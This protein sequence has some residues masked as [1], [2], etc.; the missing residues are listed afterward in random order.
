MESVQN[1]QSRVEAIN[2]SL[3]PE[4]IL[5]DFNQSLN[6][7][8]LDNAENRKMFSVFEV[9]QLRQLKPDTGFRYL[10][11]DFIGQIA[12]SDVMKNRL[13]LLELVI[14][15]LSDSQSYDEARPKRLMKAGSPQA[16]LRRTA[17][18][19]YKGLIIP[20]QN[21]QMGKFK[22]VE[23]PIGTDSSLRRPSVD[24]ALENIGPVWRWDGNFRFDNQ[25]FSS[26]NER[27]VSQLVRSSERY[28][29]FER[30]ELFREEYDLI[31]LLNQRLGEPPY[32][33]R[34]MKELRHTQYSEFLPKPYKHESIRSSVEAGHNLTLAVEDLWRKAGIIN[35]DLK[36]SSIRERSN[37]DLVIVDWGVN[38]QLVPGETKL[39]SDKITGGSSLFFPPEAVQP[40]LGT[41]DDKNFNVE[42]YLIYQIGA[43]IFADIFPVKQ[44]NN[45][46]REM[47]GYRWNMPKYADNGAEDAV[48]I[49][50]NTYD[51]VRE[52]CSEIKIPTEVDLI[53]RKMLDPNPENRPRF[54][55]V[56]RV[57]REASYSG[58][59]TNQG[60]L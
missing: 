36:P 10:D 4:Q 53:L 26:T 59:D 29:D 13:Q 31:R 50:N 34:V 14:K 27:H 18:I 37:G 42:P 35:L 47:K 8:Y 11:S 25:N 54:D 3:S 16:K 49:T 17:A 40:T 7:K 9:D 60:G 39:P 57:L 55:E 48:S 38:A 51:A 24:K 58:S 15:Y 1:P 33:P 28:V 5:I 20:E 21:V 23:S 45:A 43:T 30:R 22:S 46:I 41:E 52:T 32:L 12:K 6:K 19:L 44:V 56:K 2:R